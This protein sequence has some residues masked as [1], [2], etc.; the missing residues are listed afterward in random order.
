M[1]SF[2]FSQVTESRA[3]KTIDVQSAGT[4]KMELYEGSHDFGTI[5]QGE[6]VSHTFKFKNTG[7]APLVIEKT[8]VSCGCTTPTYTKKPIMPG[9]EGEITVEFNSNGKTGRQDKEVMVY[10][11]NIESSP[12]ILSFICIVKTD[13]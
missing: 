11:N 9:E 6:I 10:Y 3:T 8:G 1:W 4:S 2:S 7:N 5:Q 13:S 12:V